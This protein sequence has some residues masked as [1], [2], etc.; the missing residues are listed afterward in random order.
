MMYWKMET[1]WYAMVVTAAVWSDGEIPLPNTDNVTV[2]DT[3]ATIY[4]GLIDMHNHLHHNTAP[5]WR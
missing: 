5:L 4:P 3:N 2:H 1:L